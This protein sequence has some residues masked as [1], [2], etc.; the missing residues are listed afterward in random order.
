MKWV[1]GVIAA[2][3]LAVYGYVRLHAYSQTFQFR[4]TMTVSMPEGEKSASSVIAVDLPSDMRTQ[5]ATGI[6]RGTTYGI[7]PILDLA[8]YGTLIAALTSRT[9]DPEANRLSPTGNV[10]GRDIDS[11][12]PAAYDLPW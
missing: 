7:A 6:V 1:L 11:L 9:G 8:Q 10:R 3:V 12:I 5:G 4:M 2:I